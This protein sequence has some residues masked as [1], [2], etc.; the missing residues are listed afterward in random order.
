M[1]FMFHRGLGIPL[2]AVAAVAVGLSTRPGVM[3]SAIAL[4]G[5]AAVGCTMPAFARWLRTRR[6]LVEVLPAVDQDPA[7]PAGILIT[8]GTR[9]RTL[10]DAID[11]RAQKANDAAD[12]VRMDDDG[13][14]A[15][16]PRVGSNE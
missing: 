7:P 3:P 5:I 16:G 12:L 2:W 13:G 9:T 14:L 4:L 8:G 6:P 10:S 11:R 1:A 15:A